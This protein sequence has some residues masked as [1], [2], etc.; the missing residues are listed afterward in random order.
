L[1]ALHILHKWN[2]VS[3][4]TT[5]P[6]DAEKKPALLSLIGGSS[7]TSEHAHAKALQLGLKWKKKASESKDEENKPLLD[8]EKASVQEPEDSDD[9]DDEK[10]EDPTKSFGKNLAKAIVL[11]VLGTAVVAFFSDP[12]VDV[13]GDF[14]VSIKVKPF[15]VSFLITPFCSNASELISSLIFAAK[16][17]RTNSSLT[18]SQLYGAATMNNTLCLGIFFALIYFRGLVWSYTAETLAILLVTW[19]VGAIGGTRVN[20][21][22][23]WA[24]IVISL[25]PLS[26]L[27]VWGLEYGVHWA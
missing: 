24:F 10:E 9:E 14:A 1:R 12:M 17:R 8:A 22:V 19:I 16:K 11:L 6:A 15:F 7:S 23:F 26:L 3:K 21:S 27:F 25:Y 18:F 20:F 5:N 13:I 4:A 2:P